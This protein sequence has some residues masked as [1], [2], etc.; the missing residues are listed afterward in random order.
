MSPRQ[1]ESRLS[2]ASGASETELRLRA[3]G[4]YLIGGDLPAAV[5][6]E[7]ELSAFPLS[8]TQRWRFELLQAERLALEGS[9]DEAMEKV[10]DARVSISSPQQAHQLLISHAQVL[11]SMRREHEAQQR[12]L[13]QSPDRRDQV[14]RDVFWKALIFAPPWNENENSVAVS[15]IQTDGGPHAW[16]QLS[17]E[18]L[19]APNLKEQQRRLL[20]A[21]DK[22]SGSIDRESLPQTL[23]LITEASTGPMRVGLV[24]PLSGQLRSLGNAFL[25]GFASAWFASASDTQVRF[26]VYDADLLNTD[27]DYTRLASELIGERV[28]V[29]VGPVSRSKLDRFHAVLPRE[30]GWIALNPVQNAAFLQDGHFVLELSME[31]EIKSLARRIQAQ[32]ARRILAYHSQSGWSRRA[33]DTLRDT[34][35]LE[36]LIGSV[37][38]SGVAAV[39]GEVG[40]SLLVDG[41][42]ARIRGIERLLQG[43]VE[44]KARRRQDIDAIVALVDG[45]LSSALGPA[46]RYHDAGDVPLF[47]TSRMLWEVHKGDRHTFEGARFLELPWNLTDS[48]LK[49][50]LLKEFGQAPPM[51]GTFRAVGVDCFRLVD[52]FHLLR[53]LQRRSLFDA[54]QGSG[55]LLSISGNQVI[56]QLAWSQVRPGGVVAVS[57]DE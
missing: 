33:A 19:S 9:F 13:G 49:R 27:A 10:S 15:E 45:R 8:A 41:S 37:E 48:D 24:L 17:S 46:L 57:D 25:E 4:G 53:T 32:G 47:G 44:T 20:R 2:T 5:R 56:R 30:L 34:L 55:G 54:L 22:A 3:L 18:L 29:V 11:I 50:R 16:R 23:Q 52:R 36:A 28:Q 21:L 26:T 1:L 31:D 14:W 38:L 51:M 12:L 6:V 35:G 43:A 42:Q 39:T 7:S 40:L